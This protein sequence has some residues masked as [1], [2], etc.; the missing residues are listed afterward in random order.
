MV[1]A[2]GAGHEGEEEDCQL[3]QQAEGHVDEEGER[4]DGAR[5]RERDEVAGARPLARRGRA[6][7]EAAR[8]R[9]LAEVEQHVARDAPCEVARGEQRQPHGAR[10]P[11]AQVAAHEPHLVRVRV[12]VRVG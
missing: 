9:R 5:E 8:G 4:A 3:Q 10:Q 2:P 12:R 7:G 11:Q 1:H 6:D